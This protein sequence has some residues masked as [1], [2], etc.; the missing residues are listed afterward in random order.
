MKVLAVAVAA[1]L[2]AALFAAVG[3]L[4]WAVWN[5]GLSF[6]PWVALHPLTYWQGVMLGLL[7]ILVPNLFR[8]G[9]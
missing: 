5:F 1:V 8:R 6:I 3:V 4:V 2:M 9:D 7:L